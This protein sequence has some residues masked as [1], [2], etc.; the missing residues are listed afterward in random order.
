MVTMLI[1]LCGFCERKQKNCIGNV[2]VQL[3]EPLADKLYGQ[4]ST[5]TVEPGQRLAKDPTVFVKEN[6]PDFRPGHFGG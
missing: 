6:A 4:I 5:L 1:F 3:S 2:E